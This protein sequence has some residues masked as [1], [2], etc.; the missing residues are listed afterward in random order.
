MVFLYEGVYLQKVDW[1]F[2]A[3]E[4]LS[5]ASLAR[6]GSRRALFNTSL[7]RSSSITEEKN[8]TT[9]LQT[10]KGEKISLARA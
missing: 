2:Y 8:L 10:L 5:P 9:N 6:V 7:I 4:N 1:F 3:R